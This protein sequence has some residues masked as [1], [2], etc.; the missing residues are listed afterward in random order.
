MLRTATDTAFVRS[1]LDA[2]DDDAPRLVYA[3]WLDEHGEADR[4]EFIRLQIRAAHAGPGD[5]EAGALRQR[6]EDLR[7]AHHVEWLNHLPQFEGV[8]WESF[9]RGF[10]SA[11]RFDH[12]DLFFEHAA[13]VFAAAPV[14]VVQFHQAYHTHATRLAGVR[15]LRR[16]RTL[17][18]LD[19]NKVANIGVEAL[20]GSRHLANLTGLIL[21]RNSLGSA[22]VRSIAMSGYVR[23]LR[24]LRLDQ[25]DLYDDGLRYVAESRALAGLEQLDLDRTR[26]GDDGVK[27]L[28]R[29]PHVRKL[30]QLFLSN[31]LI[32]D[33]GV[34]A[35]AASA[36]VANLRD[37]YLSRNAISDRGIAALAGSP[38]LARL[39]RLHVR[40]N[41]ISDEGALVLAQSPYLDRLGELAIGEN[42]LVSDQARDA[43]RA[44]FRSRLR[45]NLY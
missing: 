18:F 22:G 15:D 9:E 37:L 36:A 19:G 17:D 6:A 7:R 24:R 45:F 41:Q 4:A 23:G 44:R 2:P 43:L 34:E 14:Q 8:H 1:I 20:M 38:Y 40:E 13:D 26:T 29:S 10:I 30:R 33:Q 39:E 25:N 5:P 27:A 35:L 32:T 31:N 3:D 12:P 28:A 16:V 42:R 11:V 21:G